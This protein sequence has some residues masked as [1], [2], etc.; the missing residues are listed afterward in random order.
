[1]KLKTTKWVNIIIMIAFFSVLCSPA[2]AD[3][4]ESPEEP[5]VFELIEILGIS[6]LSGLLLSFFTGIFRK[7]LGRKFMTVHKVLAWITVIIALTH[8]TTVLIVF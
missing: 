2:W 1:M 7:K 3:T 5:F 4:P 8:G 6:A